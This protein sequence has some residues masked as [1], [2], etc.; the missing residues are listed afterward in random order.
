MKATAIKKICTKL[1]NLDVNL[2]NYIA[3]DFFAREG[4]WQ[5]QYYANQV[6]KIYAWEVN[7][8]Y[9]QNLKNNLPHTATVTIGDSFALAAHKK[10]F[11]DMIVLD[12][13]M[14]CFGKDNEYCEHFE[15]LKVSLSMLKKL[16]GVLVFNIKT[17]PFN[18]EDKITWQKRR[19]DFYS[20]N[21]ASNLS[22]QFI[23]DFYHN[24]FNSYDYKTLFSFWE[25]RPQEPGLYAFVTRIQRKHNET[26]RKHN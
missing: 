2:A 14:G 8:E 20:V 4:N 18:Y 9:E 10:H 16:G 6:A 19:N 11:F 5:T 15:A 12:N 24:F 13:P 1:E 21:D 3:L 23:F 26:D 17:Q 25:K 22:K 7:P